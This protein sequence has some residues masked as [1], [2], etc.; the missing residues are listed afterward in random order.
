MAIEVQLPGPLRNYTGQQSRV[1]A[2]GSTVGEVLQNLQAQY[3][4]LGSQLY[5]ADGSVRRFINLFVNGEDIRGQNGLDTQLKSGDKLGIL[6][7]MAGGS[8]S[9]SPD[10]VQRYHRHLIMPEVGSRGQ[11]RLANAKV[12][13]VGAGGLGSPA[14]MYLAAAG[15]GK[16]GI[17][18]FDVVDVSNLQRQILHGSEDV[19]RPKVDSARDT[20]ARINPTV[21]VVAHNEPLTSQN[22]REIIRDYDIVV[23]GTD[24]FP[25]RYLVNDVCQFEGKPLVDG[26][27][28]RFDGQ[29]TVYA[30]GHG[31]YRD[32]F[33]APPPPGA[34][35]SCAEAGVLGVL[36]GIVG[37]LQALEAIKLILGVGEPMV[38]R[39]LLFD[40]L[41]MEFRELKLRKDPNCPVCGEH[42]TIT[43][44]IDYVQFCG[45]P[46]QT[47]LIG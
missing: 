9:L 7:A 42:P 21:E 14:A 46:Q 4:G 44:P 39:M 6:P 34:V 43:E 33:P 13:I 19:G 29:L 45:V 17:A 23:N 32:L 25:T 36:P 12:L 1:Q 8:Q 28:M 27:I 15:V 16:I 22:A 2:E 38:G 26:S 35:P 40:G 47:A 37:S 31:C 20:I 3:P 41:S 10:Q 5:E 30:P 11:R 18:D 24:N